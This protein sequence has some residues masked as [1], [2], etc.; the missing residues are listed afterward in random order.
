AAI[1]GGVVYA[2]APYHFARSIQI[3]LA[4]IQ[5]LP[6]G[7]WA[8][9]WLSKSP[10]W[11]RAAVPAACSALIVLTT[12]YYGYLYA[13]AS[14]VFWIGL[15]A[16]QTDKKTRDE[17]LRW[18]ALATLGGA[19]VV[20]AWYLPL[21]YAP[22][23]SRAAGQNQ[24]LSFQMQYGWPIKHLFVYC[25]KPWDYFLPS[26][27]HPFFGNWAKAFAQSHLYGSNVI[28]QTLFLGYAVIGLAMSAILLGIR[29]KTID[30]KVRL[31]IG[32]FAGLGLTSLWFSGPP[33]IP[34][35]SFTIENDQILSKFALYFPSWWVHRLLNL[36]FRVYARF[37]LLVL[38]A[39]AA[40]AGIAWTK[41]FQKNRPA[42]LLL[43]AI[44]IFEYALVMPLRAIGETPP[45]YAWLK[46]QPPGTV[47][48]EYP[49]VGSDRSI[50]AEYLFYQR[51]HG[52]PMI[53]GG[54][55][56][57][58]AKSSP[59]PDSV[60]LMSEKTVRNLKGR[61]VRY[62]IVHRDLYK[63]MPRRPKQIEVFGVHYQVPQ[64]HPEESLPPPPD[65]IPGLNKV[66]AFPEADVYQIS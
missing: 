63:Q 61:G 40:L 17:F 5:W 45:V 33:F 2:C 59:R 13:V 41:L 47:I 39:A 19:A 20:L 54:Y 42:A 28:E 65:K 30:S 24:S 31:G 6:L 58:H 55:E 52:K 1:V 38:L 16:A 44:M 21:W 25:A 29:S 49:Y 18:S 7:L 46:D 32:L 22:F 23:A 4:S 3:T 26:V 37:G 64:R 50:H 43:S 14:L 34:I 27:H 8:W 48:A 60:D 51:I 66:Q 35:G 10:S 9:V 53:N 11:K 12:A 15:W 36:P 56:P 62:V 57:N